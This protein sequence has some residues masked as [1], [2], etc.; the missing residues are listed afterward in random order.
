MYGFKNVIDVCVMALLYNLI[1]VID[2]IHKT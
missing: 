1:E 2:L